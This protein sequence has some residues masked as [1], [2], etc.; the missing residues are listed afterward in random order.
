[1]NGAAIEL[2]EVRSPSRRPGESLD[3]AISLPRILSAPGV[4]LCSPHPMLG[5]NLDNNVMRALARAVA[6]SGRAAARFDYRGVGDSEDV[7]P[8]RSRFEYWQDVDRRGDFAATLADSCEALERTRRFFD[9]GAIGG[10]SFGA[11]VALRLAERIDP[12]IPLMLVAPPLTRLDFSSLEHRH[13]PSLV[14]LAELDALDPPPPRSMLEARFPN[15]TISVLPGVD[16]FFRGAEH[17]SAARAVEFLRAA[18][19]TRRSR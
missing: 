17:D 8:S 19:G 5:G 18:D 11:W 1:M 14:V 15:S 4:L 13:G 10:Y 2:D 12:T 6:A 3:L 7:D 9:V 16:H